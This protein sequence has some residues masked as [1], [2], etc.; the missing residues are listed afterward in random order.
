MAR[1]LLY[2]LIIF[3]SV[4]FSVCKFICLIVFLSVPLF[5]YL[6]NTSLLWPV[7]SCYDGKGV[8]RGSMLQ[9]SRI[10]EDLLTFKGFTWISTG[11][12]NGTMYIP[13]IKGFQDQ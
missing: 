5:P 13:V 6:S 11:G 8:L 2:F 12:T 4:R 7:C 3:L 9:K 1:V 10:S